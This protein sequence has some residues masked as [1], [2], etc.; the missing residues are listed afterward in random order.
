MSVRVI[1][2]TCFLLYINLLSIIVFVIKSVVVLIN[3]F[4]YLKKVNV[5]FFS[6]SFCFGCFVASC[7]SQGSASYCSIADVS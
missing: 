1:N 3:F 6:L 2:K 7:T 4:Y 5:A